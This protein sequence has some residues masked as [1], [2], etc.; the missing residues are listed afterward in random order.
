M[1]EHK[2]L[3]YQGP[4]RYLCTRTLYSAPQVIKKTI[5]VS[6]EACAVAES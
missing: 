2:G 5:R 3:A 4:L 6:E 1:L